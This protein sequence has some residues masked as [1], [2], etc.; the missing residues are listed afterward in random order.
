[1]THTH[2]DKHTLVTA[3]ELM[4]N[5]VCG[6]RICKC[7]IK[8]QCI[9]PRNWY[10]YSSVKTSYICDCSYGAR[11]TIF[12]VTVFRVSWWCVYWSTVR[13]ILHLQISFYV[14]VILKLTTG[15]LVLEIWYG[16]NRFILWW[17]L[18]TFELQK[19][20]LGR[21]NSCQ[22]GVFQPVFKVSLLVFFFLKLK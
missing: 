6:A 5:W 17:W 19:I 4:Q 9:Q 22:S 18:W 15:K 13:I 20:S 16:Y 14:P 10:T 2:T 8:F 11:K 3:S 1:M 7:A 12:H 21:W